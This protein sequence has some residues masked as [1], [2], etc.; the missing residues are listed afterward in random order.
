M[1]VFAKVFTLSLMVLVSLVTAPA[2]QA[3]THSDEER[4]IEMRFLGRDHVTI[5]SAITAELNTSFST[6]AELII[7]N[8]LGKQFVN[9]RIALDQGMNLLKF[10]VAEI[11]QG[12]YFVKVKTGDKVQTLTFFVVR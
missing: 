3:A 11:P 12:A 4:S 10:R 1:K 5:G 6:E 9:T 2:A 8:D 7:E